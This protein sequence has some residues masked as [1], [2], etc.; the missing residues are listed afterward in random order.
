MPLANIKQP[1]VIQISE[2]LRLRRTDENEAETALPWY[3]NRQ[4]LYYSEGLTE[5]SY[6]LSLVQRMYKYLAGIGELY[7]TEILDNQNWLTIGDVTLSEENMPIVLGNERFW[8][9][10]FGKQVIG[11]LLERAQLIGL[12][13]IYIPAIYKYNE[14]SRRLFTSSGF[15]KVAET[16]IDESF[17]IRF[18]AD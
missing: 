16:E 1:G 8:G 6:D 12:E 11:R 2:I 15:T 18:V 5:G 17:E 10:G 3:Q 13:R 14:R 4:I 9:R 7:F